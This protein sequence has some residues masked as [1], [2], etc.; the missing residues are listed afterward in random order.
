[1]RKMHSVNVIEEKKTEN[2]RIAP[3]TAL[4]LLK[5]SVKYQK[6]KTEEK[7]P[8]RRQNGTQHVNSR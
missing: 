7:Q 5:R 8:K 4:A 1:M 6:I 2:T 3:K